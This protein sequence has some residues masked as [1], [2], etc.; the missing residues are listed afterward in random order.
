[1]DARWHDAPPAAEADDSCPKARLPML[2]AQY[3]EAK[4]RADLAVA[5][6]DRLKTE[7]DEALGQT[8]QLIVGGYELRRVEGTLMRKWDNRQLN[9]LLFALRQTENH[10]LAETIEACRIEEPRRGYLRI[11]KAG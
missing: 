10:D 3:S 4:A 2:V 1:M 8:G 7:I 11:G 6:V 5:E 9:D